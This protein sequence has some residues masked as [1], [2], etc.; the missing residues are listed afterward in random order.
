M[1]R[2]VLIRY[3]LLVGI[4]VLAGC[5][6]PARKLETSVTSQIH[7]GLS[8]TEVEAILGAPATLETGTTGR[9]LAFYEYSRG[10]AQDNLD[11]TLRCLSVLY[12]RQFRVIEVL[13]HE[14]TLNYDHG[15]F[16]GDRVGKVFS[17]E[18]IVRVM[19]PGVTREDV[20]KAFGNPMWEYLTFDGG[21]R[22][23]WL[24]AQENPWAWR[25]QLKGWSFV[26]ICDPAGL[27]VDFTV[28]G[29]MEAQ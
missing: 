26:V 14:G 7:P 6:T 28:S 15:L 9:S 22:M 27:M 17:R 25:N 29:N 24:A 16:R 10:S 20:V 18:E 13:R 11:R 19:T 4:L 3:T 5:A 23:V 1:L 2:L 8:R 12:D 21:R